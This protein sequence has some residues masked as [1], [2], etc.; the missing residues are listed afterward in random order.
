VSMSGFVCAG[1]LLFLRG[2]QRDMADPRPWVLD[3]FLPARA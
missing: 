3:P 2:G 1:L